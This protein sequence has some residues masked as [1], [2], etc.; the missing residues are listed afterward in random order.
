[1]G[2]NL[3]IQGYSDL[4]LHLPSLGIR[5]LHQSIRASRE[6]MIT[7]MAKAKTTTASLVTTCA[8]CC[9]DTAAAG[10]WTLSGIG[11]GKAIEL[12]VTGRK[13]KS[14]DWRCRMDTLGE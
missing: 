14:E 3:L 7:I 5:S 12:D 6:H 9:L 2:A 1:M 4:A 8:P 11:A 13:S 10:L